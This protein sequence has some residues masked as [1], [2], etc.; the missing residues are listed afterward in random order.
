M[1]TQKIAFFTSTVLNTACFVLEYKNY[2]TSKINFFF[3]IFLYYVCTGMA[4]AWSLHANKKRM[5]LS[6]TVANVLVLLVVISDL[7]LHTLD[8]PHQNNKKGKENLK[9][10]QQNST[11]K[12]NDYKN[13]IANKPLWKNFPFDYFANQDEKRHNNSINLCNNNNN[14][15][16]PNKFLQTVR[17]IFESENLELDF[18]SCTLE[19]ECSWVEIDITDLSKITLKAYPVKD[20]LN[21]RTLLYLLKEELCWLEYI[22]SLNDEEKRE[23]E[24]GFTTYDKGHG[25]D[26][27]I[28]YLLNTYD[29]ESFKK[30]AANRSKKT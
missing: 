29:K 7:V 14:H 12:E 15:S 17:D 2:K 16:D 22:Q 28:F 25:F 11:E 26:D 9:Q 4:Y 19:T 10:N 23:M 5:S 3:A 21:T 1:K 20:Y 13:P 6:I 30:W 8:Q 27:M 18:N 24:E